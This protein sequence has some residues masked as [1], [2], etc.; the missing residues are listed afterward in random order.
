MIISLINL[1]PTAKRKPVNNSLSE[2]AIN[3]I[4]RNFHDSNLSI[5]SIAD[6]LGVSIQYLSVSF[7]KQTG[8]GILTYLHKVR[9]DK[10]KDLL[11]NTKM[12]IKDI[13]GKVGYYTDIGFIRAFK[14]YEGLTPGKYREMRGNG[15][16][17]V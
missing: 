4:T 17:S 8:S 12:S 2:G 13:S 15:G 16:N 14:R 11:V 7:K 10:A 1:F 5:N 6:E 9:R 3:Y